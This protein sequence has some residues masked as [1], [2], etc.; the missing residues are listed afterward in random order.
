MAP[1]LE[2]DCD[3]GNVGREQ[4]VRMLQFLVMRKLM[5]MPYIWQEA[6]FCSACEDHITI[7]FC[8]FFVEKTY[9]I[10]TH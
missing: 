10:N 3:G 9:E 5:H 6:S 7:V 1:A 2:G 4:P 8:C